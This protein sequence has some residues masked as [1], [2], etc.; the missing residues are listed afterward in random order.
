MNRKVTGI[1]GLILIA[2][3]AVSLIWGGI[4]Y[5]SREDVIELGDVE[6]EAETQERVPLPPVLGGIALLGGVVLVAV[7]RRP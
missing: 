3:G 4:E 7:S 1:V 6:V 2:I 5:T